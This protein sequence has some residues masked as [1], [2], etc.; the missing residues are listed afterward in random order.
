MLGENL[1]ILESPYSSSV[2]LYYGDIYIEG[3][4]I[5]IVVCNE[6]GGTL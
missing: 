6:G 5:V 1:M 2:A 3:F 4:T